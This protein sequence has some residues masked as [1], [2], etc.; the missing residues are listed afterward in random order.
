[1]G[2]HLYCSE[3]RKDNKRAT[4]TG[5]G[6]TNQVD[7]ASKNAIRQQVLAR[8]TQKCRACGQRAYNVA[9]LNPPAYGGPHC[10]ENLMA[11]CDVCLPVGRHL[12]FQTIEAKVAYL[13][14]SRKLP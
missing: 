7:P 2:R 5:G 9:Y 11:V 8:D 4:T 14:R 1:M 13:R 6:I 10:E 12:A 3:C